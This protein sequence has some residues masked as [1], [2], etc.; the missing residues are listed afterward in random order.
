MLYNIKISNGDRLDVINYINS[1]RKVN[2]NY[3]VVDVGGAHGGWSAP[4]YYD[5]QSAS[6]IS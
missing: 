4:Y 6:T 5:E 2:P 3:K 1:C